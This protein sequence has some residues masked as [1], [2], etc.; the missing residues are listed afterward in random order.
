MTGSIIDASVSAPPAEVT[1]EVCVIGSGYGGATAAWQL[2]QLGREVLVLEEGGDFTGRKLT[3]RDG[4]MY[5]QLYMDRG[6][7]ATSDLGIS[8]LQG[9]VLGGGGTINA[10]DVVP[11]SD[12]VAQHWETKFGLADFSPGLL[13]PFRAAALEDLSA[14]TPADSE[15]NENNLIMKRGAEKL[16]FRGGVMMHNRVDCAN[17]GT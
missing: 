7:R 2:A 11:L 10:C 5:D 6:G 14:S 17:V 9:R 12:E 1:V 13:E 16:G 8:V 3:G 15:L 4:E